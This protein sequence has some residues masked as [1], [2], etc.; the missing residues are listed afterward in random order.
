MNHQPKYICHKGDYINM[1]DKADNMCTDIPSGTDIETAWRTITNNIKELMDQCI[2]KTRPTRNGK[3]KP[4]YM[5][6]KARDKVIEK[7]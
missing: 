7:K 3:K 2:P 1:S 6:A 5:M 4:P